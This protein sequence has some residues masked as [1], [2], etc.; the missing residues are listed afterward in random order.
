MKLQKTVL[1]GTVLSII[2]FLSVHAFGAPDHTKTPVFFVHG[3]GVAADVWDPMIADL[4][5]SGYPPEF[6]EAIQLVPDNGANIPAAEEQIAPAIET[7]LDSINAFLAA[8]YPE[9]APKTKVDM[10]SHSMGSLSSRWYAAQVRPD[11]VDKWVSLAGANHGTDFAC[12]FPPSDPSRDDMCPAYATSEQESF[13]QFTLNGAPFVGDVD[14]TPY[15]IG[16]DSSGVMV[17]PPDQTRGILY[18]TIRTSPDSLI[19]PDDSPILDGAG[20]VQ[21]PIPG[22]L[23]ATMTSEGNFLMTNGV[24]HD[25]MLSDPETVEL[26]RFI[27]DEVHFLLTSSGDSIG[28]HVESGGNIT[29]LN[30]IDPSAIPDSSDK[31]DNLIYDLIDMQVRVDVPGDAAKVTISLPSPA[32]PEF[33]WFKYSQTNGWSDY[34]VNAE[35][36][37]T[38][39]QITLTLIDG[40]VGDDDGLPPNGLIDDPSGLGTVASTGGG[41]GGGGGCFIATAGYGSSMAPG[42]IT[43]RKFCDRFLDD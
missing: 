21:L 22:D 1:I 4:I 2:T 38:R 28:V 6:L 24:G 12:S 32:P 39:D 35:F 10:V 40:G 5:A 19:D 15:G 20:G 43:L 41:G 37:P 16:D 25:P 8:T 27:L 42:I 9:I 14:E 18:V 17:V 7:F 11:R 31:P 34:S 33:R 36:N 23:P 30:A 3:H 29:E 13:V 26:V